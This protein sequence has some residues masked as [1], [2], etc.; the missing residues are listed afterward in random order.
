[1]SGLWLQPVKV[2]HTFFSVAKCICSCTKCSRQQQI[3]KNEFWWLACSLYWLV[4]HG[5]ASAGRKKAELNQTC[6]LDFSRSP[7]GRMGAHFSTRPTTGSL[8]CTTDSSSTRNDRLLLAQTTVQGNP[9]VDW[10]SRVAVHLPWNKQTPL[11]K[12]QRSGH[13]REILKLS[14]WPIYRPHPTS[15]C[16]D[17]LE[18]HS[19]PG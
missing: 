14:N 8:L 9:V 13:R 17:S 12:I 1:M 16:L 2:P 7:W 19:S 15:Q 10:Y 5:F 6:A 18:T 3:H 11:I 4:S